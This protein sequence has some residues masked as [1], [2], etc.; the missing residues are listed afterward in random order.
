MDLDLSR[1]AQADL[2]ARDLPTYRKLELAPGT[3]QLRVAVSHDGR[4]GSSA[5]TVTVPAPTVFRISTPILSDSAR[6]ASEGRPPQP[7]PV[8]HRTFPTG[9]TLLCLYGVYGAKV[10]P[11]TR[12]PRAA[13]SLT[14]G[15]VGGEPLIRR[16]SLDLP[17]AADGSLAETVPLVLRG[18]APGD[19]ELTI[20][21]ED[22][23]SGTA[24][25]R[26]ERF[27]VR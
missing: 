12:A 17:A 14:I 8:A 1:A 6:P 22:Q 23:V 5:Q 26:H 20:R 27:S 18:A 9:S 19:Y 2:R 25:E 10:D 13:A 3:Y 4:I 15:P 11:A 7:I 21:V 24:V 16:T